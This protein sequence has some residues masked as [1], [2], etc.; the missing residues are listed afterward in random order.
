MSSEIDIWLKD[1][2]LTNYAPLFAQNGL[3]EI[4][5]CAHLTRVS[6]EQMGI[7]LPGHLMRIERSLSKLNPSQN[8]NVTEEVLN[9]NQ[10]KDNKNFPL[11]QLKLPYNTAII[12][13]KHYNNR[14]S[15]SLENIREDYTGLNSNYTNPNLRTDMWVI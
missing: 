2:K 1:L 4:S 5:Q 13:N 11:V 15:T 8:D 10:M 14:K 3:T 12:I 6:L 7:T 9:I